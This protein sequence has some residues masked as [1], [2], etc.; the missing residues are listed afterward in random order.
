MVSF[1]L[2]SIIDQGGFCQIFQA[3]RESDGLECVIKQ[4]I[5]ASDEESSQ[6][7]KREVRI[8]KNL[9]HKNI[10]PILGSGLD[11]KPPWYA[12]PKAIMSLDQLLKESHGEELSWIFEEILGAICYAH[13]EGVIHRDIKPS[14]VLIFRTEDQQLYSCVSDFGIGRFVNRDTVTL[15]QTDINLGT[16]HYMAPEQEINAKDVDERADIFSLGKILFAILTREL[17]RTP[18]DFNH[19]SLPRRFVQLIQKATQ[20]APDARYQTVASLLDAFG[21]LNTPEAGFI[22]SSEEV[23]ALIASIESVETDM[24]QLVSELAGAL[25]RNSGDSE[26]LTNVFPRI[27]GELLKSL[28]SHELSMLKLTLQVYDTQIASES[29]RFEYCD[30]V[31]NFYEELFNYVDDH[32]VRELILRRLPSLGY[33][34]NRWHV[35]LTFGRLV[36]NLKDPALIFLVKEILESD[37]SLA[38]WCKSHVNQTQSPSA[39]RK[40][41]DSV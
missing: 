25:Y 10:V 35:G 13:S 41:F 23:N 4:P 40:V 17:P 28:F 20:S 31:A 38:A 11:A 8:M 18:L 1:K 26:M 9:V 16:Y 37:P 27:R 3:T 7:F 2:G 22:N 19:S 14:N 12:M 5:D 21:D 39:I 30:T 6:R 24:P 36:T 29:L 32:E 15:T 33:N 34:H